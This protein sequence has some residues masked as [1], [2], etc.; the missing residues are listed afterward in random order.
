M[1]FY[2]FEG[3][4][5]AIEVANNCCGFWHRL[6]NIESG[7]CTYW[8]PYAQATILGDEVGVTPYFVGGD[9]VKIVSLPEFIEIMTVGPKK[10]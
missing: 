10:S 1:N 7:K 4:K 2:K 9:D 3:K 8:A 5:C 6:R